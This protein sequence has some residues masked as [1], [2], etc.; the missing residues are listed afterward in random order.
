VL[1]SGQSGGVAVYL[2]DTTG[3][4][5]ATGK[6][7]TPFAGYTG[8]IRTAVADFNGDGVA[9]YAFTAGAGIWARVRIVDGASGQ[10][11]VNTSR[12]LNGYTG[13]AFIVGGDIDGD[14]TAE[15]IVSA[16]SGRSPMVEMYRVSGGQ[17]V[18]QMTFTPFPKVNTGG[19][20]VAMGDLNHDG[21]ADL[22]MGTGP[23]YGSRV[24]MYDGAALAA[25]RIS[26]LRTSFVPFDAT[27]NK[28]VN[29]ASGD[30]NG[31][32]Y[33]DLI[34]SQDAGGTSLVRVWSGAAITANP[35]T[36]V[37][38]L[39]PLQEFYANGT[40]DTSGIRVT[41]RDLDG[42]GSAEL[43]TTPSGGTAGWMRVLAVT[44]SAVTAE[45]TVFP[46]PGGSLLA[47]IYVG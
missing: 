45:E 15:L 31:D 33:D 24:A 41:T 46:Y 14:G 18:K 30:I 43:V 29:V 40:S 4:L 38:S 21:A 47:G 20:R 17:L 2:R 37:G 7:F 12:V 5:A 3:T 42:N 6:T 9:D 35:G 26:P 8:P 39:P 34:V 16:D 19:V 44:S 27:A 1:V 11:L 25:R 23:G 10:M 36:P 13:G 22:I 28:G 32:G